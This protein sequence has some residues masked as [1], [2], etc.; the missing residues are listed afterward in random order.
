MNTLLVGATGLVGRDCLR[1]LVAE[2]AISRVVVL[3]RRPLPPAAL[4]PK[5]E[6]RILDFDRL[7][8]A[9][10]FPAVDAV[11]CALGTTI[12]QAGSQL[13]FREVDYGYPLA[14]A[15]L[16]LAQ[17]ARHFLLVSALGANAQS[18]VFYNRVKGEV[19][20][21]IRSLGYRSVTIARP[22]F[23]VGERDEIRLGERIMTPLA[24][25]MP[26]RLRPVKAAAVAG[27]LVAAAVRDEAGVRILES[28]VIRRAVGRS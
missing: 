23:L 18:R 26:G 24:F 6:V 17:G 8:S 13:R 28:E 19:E 2:P 10:V 20:N 11:L 1:L 16:A 12:R 21:A 22:S 3:A 7:E 15:R 4:A 14:V 5:V 9:G 25:L 27:A